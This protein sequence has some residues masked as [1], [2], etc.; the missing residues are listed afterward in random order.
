MV[1]VFAFDKFHYYLVLLKVI[2]YTNYS[3]LRY[4]LSKLD[5]KP[6]LIR[7]ILLLQDFDLKIRD[8]KGVEN[9]AVD[10]LSC[11]ENPSM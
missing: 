6:H 7:R 3:A 5:A 8:K 10:H 4:L 1:V 11:L 9:V 2:V